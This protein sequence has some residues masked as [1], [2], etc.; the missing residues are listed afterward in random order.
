MDVRHPNRT[1][2][3]P[4]AREGCPRYPSARLAAVVPTEFVSRT[5]EVG[6]SVRRCLRAEVFEV[7]DDDRVV[8][9]G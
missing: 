6:P 4:P 9:Q 8:R 3:I 1:P 7:T 5:L 2:G